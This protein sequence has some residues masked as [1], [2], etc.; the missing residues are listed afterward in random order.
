MQPSI[1]DLP[2]SF[3]LQ[4]FPED[5]FL[6]LPADLLSKSVRSHSSLGKFVYTL[7]FFFAIC[8]FLQRHWLGPVCK[9][10][11][12]GQSASAVSG[13]QE[14]A[15]GRGRPLC[16]PDLSSRRPCRLTA[17]RCG[18]C[19]ICARCCSGG[20]GQVLIQQCSDVVTLLLRHCFTATCSL[21][22]EFGTEI[23][24]WCMFVFLQVQQNWL[25]VSQCRYYAKSTAECQS[26]FQGSVLQVKSFFDL[27]C[28]TCATSV[29]QCNFTLLCL[30]SLQE[31]HQHVCNSR[32]SLNSTGPSQL[33]RS[34]GSFCHQSVW[35]FS[36]GTHR[37]YIIMTCLLIWHIKVPKWIPD[38]W[39]W[40]KSYVN[41]ILS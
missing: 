17:P 40:H 35:P 38:W 24:L 26:V 18:L 6:C 4:L 8:H 5:I 23:N 34:A 1:S 9:A 39:Y 22:Y 10:A 14:H 13:L 32:G 2:S 31:C 33:G 20:Q 21:N 16:S 19:A 12:W 41:P 3:L 25:S 29:Y 28:D 27:L 37:N 30:L 15:A 11:D 36:P 7:V